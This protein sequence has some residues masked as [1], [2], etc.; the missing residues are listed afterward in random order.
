MRIE[1]GVVESF[2]NGRGLGT[3]MLSGDEGRTYRFH[4]TA[5]A[6]GSRAIEPGTQVAFVTMPALGGVLEAR[7]VTPTNR[8]APLVDPGGPASG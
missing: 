3:V 5:I 2:D 1:V 7:H 6:G 8:F 4:C